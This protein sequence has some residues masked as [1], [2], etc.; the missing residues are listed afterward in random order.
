MPRVSWLLF[1]LV[2]LAGTAVLAQQ[3]EAGRKQARAIRVAPG[4]VAVDGRL[5]EDV[6]TTAPPIADFTQKE[7]TKARRPRMRCRWHL[8]T[9]TRRST[10]ARA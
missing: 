10:S 4:A 8:C 6:W 7:P 9:T 5:N 3:P 1:V 2:P